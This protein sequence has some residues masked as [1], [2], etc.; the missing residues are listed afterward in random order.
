ML[1]LSLCPY[2]I[3]QQLQPT[4]PGIS[5]VIFIFC[6][7]TVVQNIQTTWKILRSDHV[8]IGPGIYGVQLRFKLADYFLA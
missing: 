1:I 8:A 6:T 5:H 2:K 4:E 3:C 7:A